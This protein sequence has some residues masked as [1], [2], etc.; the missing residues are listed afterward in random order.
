MRTTDTEKTVKGGKARK[1]IL[2]TA[3]AMMA[4]NGPDGVSMRELSLRLKITKPVIYYY[5]KNKDELIKAAFAEGTKHFDEL[6][7][8]INDPRL[9]LEQRLARVFSRHLEFIR[10]YPD[11]P[12]CALKIMASPSSGALSS[13]A[14]DLKRRNRKALKEMLDSVAEKEGLSRSGTADIL[15]LISAVIVHFMVEARERGTASLDAALPSRLAALICAGARKGARALLLA[16]ALSAFSTPRGAAAL[17]LDIEDA[18]KMALAS[19]TTVATARETRGIYKERV[20]EYWGTVFPQLSA[21]ALYTRHLEKPLAALAGPKT[22]NTYTGSLD[23]N[24]VLWAGGKVNTAIKMAHM[25]SDASDEQLK[26]S[27]KLVSKAVRQMYYAVLLSKALADIQSEAL[28]LARQHLV[29]IEAQYRQGLASDLAVLR[30]KVEVSNTEPALTQAVNL[31][32]KGLLELKNLLGLDPETAVALS[33]RLSCAGDG[34]GEIA[35]LYKAAL[36]NRPEYRNQKLQKDLY[37]E[38]I[39]IER[40]GHFPYLS[41]FASKQYL[42]LTEHDSPRK[43][44]RTD[45]ATAGLRLSLPL[46]SGGSVSSRVRQAGMQAKIA[47]NNLRELERRIKIE[48]KEAWLTAKESSERLAS[49]TEAVATAR[50]ALA[51]TELRFRNGLASQLELNDTSLALNRSQTLYMQALHD[52]CSA[53]SELTWALGE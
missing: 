5:F 53:R 43:G 9:T 2:E 52:T 42:G 44:E 36:M 6:N 41:A 45:Y 11:M 51:A 27:Q 28:G 38:M 29:T 20:R 14:M 17:D 16:A 22:G 13:L 12:K 8:E 1:R 25:Y 39:S 30:Q 46:F 32:E 50:K 21:S 3:A 19:N 48:V 26:T 33:G 31:Y 47:D 35:E 40:A 37:H 49:Q 15:H 7:S 10:R 24:Q 4:E 23:L 18:V 34:P